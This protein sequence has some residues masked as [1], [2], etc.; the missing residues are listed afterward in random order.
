MTRIRMKAANE[1]KFDERINKT[2][3]SEKQR[4]NVIVIESGRKRIPKSEKNKFVTSP[5]TPNKIFSF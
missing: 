2:F 1:I 5:K 4:E 3:M